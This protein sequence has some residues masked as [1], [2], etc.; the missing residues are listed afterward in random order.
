MKPMLLTTSRQVYLLN[1]RYNN[2]IED[3]ADFP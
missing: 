1:I 3:D 2:E